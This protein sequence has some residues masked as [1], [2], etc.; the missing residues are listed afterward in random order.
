MSVLDRTAIGAAT[1]C[2]MLVGCATPSGPPRE[3]YTSV[4]KEVPVSCVPDTLG[5]APVGLMT[6]AQIAAIPD[7][8]TRYVAL[9]HDWFLR[10]ARMN[11]TEAV[12][13]ACQAAH[14]GP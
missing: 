1:A 14:H 7:G 6:P 4:N 5:T 3:V 13:T 9:A 12:I 8:P 10:V 2:L 11:D